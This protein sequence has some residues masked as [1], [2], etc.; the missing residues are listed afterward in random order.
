MADEEEE[1]TE[2]LGSSVSMDDVEHLLDEEDDKEDEGEEG[3]GSKKV[4][5]GSLTIDEGDDSIKGRSV[6]E[7]V[8]RVKGLERALKISEE[9]RLSGASRSEPVREE[10]PEKEPTDEEL[11][12]LMNKDGVKALQLI[13]ARIT[14]RLAA[15]V[16]RRL[17]PISAGAEDTALQDAQRRYPDEFKLF[18]KE[19]AEF[20]APLRGKN[21]LGSPQDWDNVI[22]YIRGKPGNWERFYT[23]Q[24]EKATGGGTVAREKERKGAGHSSKP[25]RGGSGSEKETGSDY[26]LDDV[27]KEIARNL[28]PGAPAAVAYREYRKWS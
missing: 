9:A 14:K 6:K 2:G 8:E 19:I 23:S 11:V 10:V 16:E 1:G 17:G 20:V 24:T 13:E 3:E 22:A 18:Q 15:H 4:D 28:M 26:G 7:V 5:V 25:M 12:D 21:A 27:Q